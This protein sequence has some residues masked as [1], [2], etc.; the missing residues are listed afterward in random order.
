MMKLMIKMMDLL[1]LK[2]K[3]KMKA[4]MLSKER[5]EL[6]QK[7]KTIKMNLTNL[8]IC[9]RNCG[10]CPSYPAVKGEALYCAGGKSSAA[11]EQNGCNCVSCP[12]YELCSEYNTAYFCINGQCGSKEDSL[13]S[14]ILSGISTTYLERFIH[15]D[16]GSNG[17][18]KAITDLHEGDTTDL[19]MNFLG[20]KEVE[21]K[22]NIPILQAS[23]TAGI[24]HKHICGGRA[25][26]STC[27]VLISEGLQNCRPRNKKEAMLAK[28]KG[29][30]PEIRLACQTTAENNITLR[31]LI[32]DDE[33]ISQAIHEGR[34]N[35]NQVGRETDVAILF[36]DIR[37]FT[38]FSEKALPYDII[39]ILNRY[40]ETIGEVID[41][42]GGY[43]DKYMGDGIMVIFG[44]DSQF[45][46]NPAV[47]A[48]NAAEKI[49]LSLKDFNKYLETK[50]DH[51]FRIGIGIHT[52]NVIVGN[53]GYSKKKEFT[54]IGDTVNT[55]S[56]IESVNKL[57]KTS[58][59]VSETT[60]NTVKDSYGW[61]KKF[62]A[63]VKGK[64][65]PV[66][67]YEP[68]FG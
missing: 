63:H 17:N 13:S 37:S 60:Y 42:H 31:R 14:S 48:M 58:V 41:H 51:Q 12:L 27:R 28:I 61:K 8:L 46:E 62:T 54:A 30:S 11:I 20:D 65:L 44:L 67:V 3:N 6:G 32:L 23:L 35:I 7:H 52:G 49:L 43:I 68:D 47:L 15:L 45:K 50:F 55:A 1:P 18:N 56:R 66:V 38:S 10:T 29:F 21:T 64:E 9:A 19:T 57:A 4:P 5:L 39:H 25:R 36:S 59:L 53:L 26:C 2:T 34:A 33:D 16:D 22:S 40:F 24:N